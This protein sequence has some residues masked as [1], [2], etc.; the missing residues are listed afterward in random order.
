MARSIDTRLT[1]LEVMASDTGQIVIVENTLEGTVSYISPDGDHHLLTDEEYQ[2][3]KHKDNV[4]VVR[5]EYVTYA[6]PD[7]EDGV[8]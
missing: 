7:L 1:L 8:L 6:Y 5:L 4:T 3:I 2:V